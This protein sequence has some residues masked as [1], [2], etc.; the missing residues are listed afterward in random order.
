MKKKKIVKFTAA[1]GIGIT[2]LGGFALETSVRPQTVQAKTKNSKKLYFT[3]N[4]YIYSHHLK[5]VKKVKKGTVM[6]YSKMV[7]LNIKGKEKKF[8]ISMFAKV[9]GG[10]ASI[11]DTLPLQ[12][13]SILKKSKNTK[14]SSQTKISS[15]TQ[16]QIDSARSR[17]LG[18]VNNWNAKK[19]R[20][21]FTIS[22]DLQSVS[23]KRAEQN[24][25]L[26]RKKG[27]ISHFLSDGTP[28]IEAPEFQK[29]G[30]TLSTEVIG[31]ANRYGKYK[32]L[33]KAV[34]R[35]FNNFIY[36]DAASGWGH[37]KALTQG[38]LTDD[39]QIGIGVSQVKRGGY[40]TLIIVANTGKAQN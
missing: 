15:L 6:A 22:S 26:Y 12:V 11:K 39:T 24:A 4:G 29:S 37:R 34:D 21:N 7:N 10:Y 27:E 2:L 31:T 33:N 14:K 5:P 36:H 20:K 13:R 17:F 9:K 19:G 8:P 28:A 18:D 30:V 3:N 1:L 32:V 38:D 16:S 23:Q 25:E 40:T 35:I